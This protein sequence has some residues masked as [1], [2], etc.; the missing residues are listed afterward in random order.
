VLDYFGTR[1]KQ[2]PVAACSINVLLDDQGAIDADQVKP[3]MRC[4]R[5][6]CVGRWPE[7]VPAPGFTPPRK[8]ARPRREKRLARKPR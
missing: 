1:G 2:L 6:G 3:H 5:Q 7:T 4:K 8:P